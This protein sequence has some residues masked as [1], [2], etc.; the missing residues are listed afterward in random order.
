M[1]RHLDATVLQLHGNI[2]EM[3]QAA[4]RNAADAGRL[5]ALAGEISRSAA[6]IGDGA[7]AQQII[8]DETSA[9][10]NE[11][12]ADIAKTS[13][14]TG[15]SASISNAAMDETS[16]CLKNMEESLRAMQ[17]ILN[18]SDQIGRITTVISQIA[19]RTNLLSLNAAIE[20]ARAGRFGRGFAVVADEIRKLAERSAQAAQERAA[21]IKESNERAANGSKSVGALNVRITGIEG[22]VRQCADIARRTSATLDEQVEIGQRT[23]GELQHIFDVIKVNS[24]AIAQMN[25]SPGQTNPM[26]GDLA[27]TSETLN[28]LAKRFRL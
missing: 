12:I 25:E 7:K 8:L 26:V 23:V 27:K 28:G 13:G 2:E 18:S 19:R 15:E 6:D 9:N 20:A 14:L 1:A 16:Q 11:L 10:L 17:E 3:A 24:D 5:S 22:K 21:L 4:D